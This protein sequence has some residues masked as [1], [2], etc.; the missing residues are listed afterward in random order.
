MDPEQTPGDGPGHSHSPLGHTRLL[1][2]LPDAGPAGIGDKPL[3]E[4]TRLGEYVLGPLLGSGG[5]GQ[6]YRALQLRPVRRE[7][8]LKL[9]HA[10]LDGPL[11][12]ALF[13]VERQALAQM[14]HPGIAQV[15]DAGTTADGFP[16]LAMELVEGEPLV[17]WCRRHALS[18]EACLRL[19]VRVCHAVHHAHLKGIIHRDLKPGNVLVRDMDGA[20]APKIIDFGIATT[21]DSAPGEAAALAGR[22]AGTPAYMSPEQAAGA[23]Q[24]LDVRSD[25]YALGVLA[26][27]ALSGTPAARLTG[28][29]SDSARSSHTTL[30]AI[31][32]GRGLPPAPGADGK[33]AVL[34]LP[35][36][37]RAVLRK[38]LAADRG[39]R[40]DSAGALAEDLQRV[41][42]RRPV[43]ALPATRRH[44]AHSFVMRHR[45][46]V[47]TAAAMVLALVTGTA[48]AVAGMNR[49]RQAEAA[50]RNEAVRATQVSGFAT[51]M[52]SSIDPEKAQ[53][54]DRTL[55]RQVFDDAA[56]RVDRDLADAHAAR[57]E[58]EGAL[59]SGYA[60]IGEGDRAMAHYQRAVAAAG[61]A[62]NRELEAELTSR[63]ASAMFGNG[64][65]VEPALALS[66]TAMDL[67]GALEPDSPVRL[68]IAS[69][70]AMLLLEDGRADEARQ[71]AEA[72]LARQRQVLGDQAE[73]TL[74]TMTAAALIAMTSGREDEAAERLDELLSLSRARHGEGDLRTVKAQ[75]MRAVA[76]NNAGDHVE[77]EALLRDVLPRIEL[78]YGPE[79]ARTL[80]VLMNLGG[81]IAG[82]PGRE[83]EALPWQRRA[84]ELAHVLQGPT[85]PYTL[86]AEANIARLLRVTGDLAG[87]ERHA[88]NAVVHS[89]G[90][91]GG[92]PIR[93]SFRRTLASIL[94]AAGRYPEAEEEL[95]QAW[96]IIDGAAGVAPDHFRRREVMDAYIG[97]YEA[98]GQPGRAAAWRSR[99]A[100][101]T[102]GSAGDGSVGAAQG[103]SADTDAK[104]DPLAGP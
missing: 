12:R 81:A 100:A 52:L 39:D 26:L 9:I 16:Y 47:A 97:L 36:A 99:R 102:A 101:I 73:D 65:A 64:R 6:V 10:R 58:I 82:Q 21:G 74:D 91:Y 50:A 34:R 24:G 62:G 45:V 11:A 30:L 38:A 60:N 33:A 13:E 76:A 56:A 7:V 63:Q 78:V 94:I 1:T 77:A 49:A 4:G 72:T 104:R 98:W 17:A 41:L 80:V 93:G 19:L 96:A 53:G 95:D 8:A 61:S 46:G 83:A 87:A 20:P 44:A 22:R 89:T 5:M 54:E 84:L 27:E 55:L 68:R 37:L 90:T 28:S 40:Y 59:A 31:L 43:Q 35:R 69:R 86:M 42:E 29:A 88:R 32:E 92:N 70:H 57:A 23:P 67:A 85:A 14:Q 48:L 25:V 103:D 18:R 71:L 79:H 75:T 15:F 51:A 66:N 2:A 3:P